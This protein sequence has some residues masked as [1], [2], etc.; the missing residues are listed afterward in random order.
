MSSATSLTFTSGWASKVRSLAATG[1]KGGTFF[2]PA[3]II[4]GGFM[5]SSALASINYRI[6][7]RSCAGYSRDKFNSWRPKLR[8]R[9]VFSS[10]A[11]LG[12]S[13]N[14]LMLKDIWSGPEAASWYSGRGYPHAL[15]GFDFSR[16]RAHRGC[17]G[18]H[19]RC[20]SGRRRRE[21]P[22]LYFYR[23]VRRLFDCPPGSKSLT[24]ML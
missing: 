14:Y 6:N 1:G 4:T 10:T 18:I 7:P 12:H 20:H 21:D 11:R 13:R 3:G 8:L 15:L 24:I 16:D 2:R 22:V 23:A 19:R 9:P 5:R 17:P